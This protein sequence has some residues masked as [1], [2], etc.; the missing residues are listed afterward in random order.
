M[1]RGDIRPC[2][3]VLDVY[4]HHFMKLT[5][6]AKRPRFADGDRLLPLHEKWG[7]EGVRLLAF[8]ADHQP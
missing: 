2:H 8:R 3:V 7:E 4:V 6:K 1:E 5:L